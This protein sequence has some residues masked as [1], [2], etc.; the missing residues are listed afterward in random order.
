MSCKTRP[1][2]SR[3]SW[4]CHS[5]GYLVSDQVQLPYWIFN[6]FWVLILLYHDPISAQINHRTNRSHSW[7]GYIPTKQRVNQFI[8]Y[9]WFKPIAR[10]TPAVFS[11][12]YKFFLSFLK[13]DLRFYCN[14][15]L[16]VKKNYIYFILIKGF[17]S[18]RKF[19][20]ITLYH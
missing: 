12:C 3:S 10:L 6:P 15:F 5:Q 2:A 18:R 17:F 20:F 8:H 19:C 7:E 14:S 1:D 4:F 13:A 9:S 11:S 16:F